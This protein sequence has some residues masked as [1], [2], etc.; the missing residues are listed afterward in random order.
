MLLAVEA[1]IETIHP[2][3]V[4]AMMAR[5]PKRIRLSRA[6]CDIKELRKSGR[7]WP[8]SSAQKGSGQLGPRCRA[9][10]EELAAVSG[11]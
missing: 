5:S 2:V 4:D 3:V 10:W 9:I 1:D 7:G 8:R 11:I 6:G